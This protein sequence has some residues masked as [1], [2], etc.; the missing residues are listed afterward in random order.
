ME[1]LKVMDRRGYAPN[2]LLPTG[3]IPTVW[4]P[5]R[6]KYL[7]IGPPK[8]GKTTFF[9]GCPDVCL[10]AFEA[11]YAEV[12]CPKIVITS[13]DRSFK[14]RKQGWNQDDDGVMYTSAMEVVE[15][16][17]NGCPYKMIVVDTLDMACKMASDH[18]CALARVETP[19]DG[20][21]YGRGWELLQTRPIRMFYNRLVKLGCGVA[22]ITHST[23]KS[24]P[25]RFGVTRPKKETSLP[26]GVQKFA[27]TQS[28]VIMHGFFSRRRKNRKERDRM[29]SFDG[30]DFLMAGTRIRK[31]YIPNKYIVTPPTRT[32]DSQPWNQWARFF[33]DNPDAGQAAEKEFVRLYVGADD[34]TTDQQKPTT[35]TKK[36]ES[37]YAGVQKGTE[38]AKPSS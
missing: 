9:S 18:Y 17:E 2:S 27:H 20:G 11:G 5:E 6:L 13:W 25:D 31:V 34:E 4:K 32:D 35:T 24:D 12:D 38:A 22:A 36:E 33:S 14:E 26:G 15:E 8:W 30:N 23:D 3:S 16:L 10:L 37:R 29:V 19:A 1:Q 21:D 28:D 7:L